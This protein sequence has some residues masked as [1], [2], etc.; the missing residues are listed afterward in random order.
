MEFIITVNV[1]LLEKQS[2]QPLSSGIIVKLYD[3]DI[4]ED[5]FLGQSN[6]DSNGNASVTFKL[7][8]I[9]SSDS[10]G[11]KLPDL[12]FTV[13]KS[14]QLLFKSI[15]LEDLNIDRLASLEAA[16]GRT[17]DLGTFVI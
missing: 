1:K 12:Y 4:F 8:D 2:G 6:V 5:D 16:K 7:E 10:P 3:K 14:G 9:A 11:E 13:F 15:V 17:I